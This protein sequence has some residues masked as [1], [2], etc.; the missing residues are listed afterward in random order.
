M[1]EAGAETVAST[2]A[3][4]RGDIATAVAAA[5]KAEQYGVTAGELPSRSQRTHRLL[6][7]V[8]ILLQGR[9]V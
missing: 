3:G 6:P 2:I 4:M 8:R 5:E 7:S 1:W 9:R